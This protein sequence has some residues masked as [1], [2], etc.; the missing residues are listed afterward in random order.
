MPHHL[1]LRGCGFL[2]MILGMATGLDFIEFV[3]DQVAALGDVSYK[4]MFGEYMVYHN[5]RPIFLVCDNTVY[6]K[7]L[8]ATADVF[9][10]HD[11]TPDVGTPYAGA[12]PHYVL[13]IEN[14][15]LSVDMARTLG[16]VLP[17]PKSKVKK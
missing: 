12:K 14:V 11:I 7:Q 8:P 17:M 5:A 15:D 6:V 2:S 13:D 1:N 4:K 16:R 9:A 10:A 3:C